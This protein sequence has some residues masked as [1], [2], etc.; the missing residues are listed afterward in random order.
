M[1][2]AHS[3]SIVTGGL[4]LCLDAGNIKGYD[5]YENLRTNSN[6]G[7]F[8]PVVGSYTFNGTSTDILAPDGSNTTYKVVASGTQQSTIDIGYQQ[9]T[10]TAGET[11]TV[12]LYY[13]ATGSTTNSRNFG[14]QVFGNGSAFTTFTLP[15]NTWVRQSLTFTASSTS[16]TGQIRV[17]SNDYANFNSESGAT[18]YLWGA[19]VERGSSANDYYAT[20]SSAKL[21][22]TNLIDV[23][24]NTN[25]AVL[26]N[27]PT[28]SSENGGS[29][30]FDGVDD[31]ALISNRSMSTSLYPF[32]YSVW[33]RASRINTDEYFLSIL[34]NSASNIFWC[35]HNASGQLNIFRR[36]TTSIVTPVNYTITTN[37]WFHTHVNYFDETSAQVYVNG[38]QTFASTTLTSV[39]GTTSANDILVGLVRTLVPSGYTRGRINNVLLYNRILSTSE[40]QQNFNAHRGRYGV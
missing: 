40:V 27:G 14:I 26:T 38:V 36:N 21:R 3:P 39:P 4:A 33:Y 24:G 23:S 11:Y 8:F 12:S 35:L 17:I 16:N 32:S 19:Q 31:Y 20:T 25:T 13:Y 5:K 29:L 6:T 18:V 30:V 1:G 37:Q 9:I 10:L 28:Y 34:D 22:G 15:Q 7:G 2:L